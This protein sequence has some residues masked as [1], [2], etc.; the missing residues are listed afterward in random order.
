[1][2]SSERL[3]VLVSSITAETDLIESLKQKYR[4]TIH[5]GMRKIEIWNPEY[6]QTKG[7]EVHCSDRFLQK[8]SLLMS[9]FKSKIVF[10]STAQ[11]EELEYKLDLKFYS[12]PLDRLHEIPTILI[13]KPPNVKEDDVISYRFVGLDWKEHR[14]L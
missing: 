7:V 4:I 14:V 11:K 6:R 2:I 5:R 12:V 1:M 10:C 13:E 9:N 3:E 8:P